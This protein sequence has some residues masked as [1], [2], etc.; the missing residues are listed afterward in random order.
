MLSMICDD[1]RNFI[2]LRERKLYA[3]QNIIPKLGCIK[4][5]AVVA[6]SLDEEEL[7]EAPSAGEALAVQGDGRGC[8]LGADDAVTDAPVLVV[9]LWA[10]FLNCFC[11]FAQSLTSTCF[12]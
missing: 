8:A 9:G 1:L 3:W 10:V 5:F 2:S 7:E 11:L 12:L 4:G 6:R